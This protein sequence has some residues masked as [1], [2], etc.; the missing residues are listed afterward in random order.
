MYGRSSQPQQS[1]SSDKNPNRVLGGLRGQGADMMSILREDGTEHKV[2]SQKYVQ[3]LEDKLRT[4][5]ARLT[6]LEKHVRRIGN[7]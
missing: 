2:P 3:G 1:R 6:T 7:D 4:T 5:E